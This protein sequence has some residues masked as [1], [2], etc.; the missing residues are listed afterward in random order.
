MFYLRGSRVFAYRVFLLCQNQPYFPGAVVLRLCGAGH[1]ESCVFVV[2]MA[3]SEHREFV[4]RCWLLTDRWYRQ[5]ALSFR[6]MAIARHLAPF[7]V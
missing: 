1:T 5:V 7:S 2:D 6:T 3:V 4:V